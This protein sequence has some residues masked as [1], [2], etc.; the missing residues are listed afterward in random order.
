MPFEIFLVVGLFFGLIYHGILVIWLEIF[1]REKRERERVIKFHYPAA[2][3][4]S[5]NLDCA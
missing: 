2:V 5:S 1:K 4:I 3:L